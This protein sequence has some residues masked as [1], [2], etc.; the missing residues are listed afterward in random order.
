MSCNVIFSV[1]REIS[2]Q[3]GIFYFKNEIKIQF[4][5]NTE[6]YKSTVMEKIK[7]IKKNKTKFITNKL[8]LKKILKYISGGEK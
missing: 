8:T 1:L 6:H 3:L 5:I 4:P 2:G 7:I